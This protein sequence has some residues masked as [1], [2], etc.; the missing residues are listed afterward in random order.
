MN[1]LYIKIDNS[2]IFYNYRYQKSKKTWTFLDKAYDKNLGVYISMLNKFIVKV[3]PF[4][5]QTP[6]NHSSLSA[7]FCYGNTKTSLSI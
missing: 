3:F 1:I 2:M 6:L 7:E 4:V 5:V